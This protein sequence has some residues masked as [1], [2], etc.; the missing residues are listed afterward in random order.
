MGER[1]LASADPRLHIP[2][3]PGATPAGCSLTRLAFNTSSYK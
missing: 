3:D 2:T 1:W